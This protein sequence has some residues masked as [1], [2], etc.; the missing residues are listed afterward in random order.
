MQYFNYA[1]YAKAFEKGISDPNMTMIAKALF[2]PIISADHVLKRKGNIYV[3][4]SKYVKAC[5][6]I[7]FEF[8]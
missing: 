2:E 5:L 6:C 1:S 8:I 3:I 4:D 7:D